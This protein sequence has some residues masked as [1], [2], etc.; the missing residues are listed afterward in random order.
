MI[1]AAAAEAPRHS[2]HSG[3]YEDIEAA[4]EVGHYTGSDS[5]TGRSLRS[6]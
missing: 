6:A 3:H 5:A 1:V 2:C 4:V